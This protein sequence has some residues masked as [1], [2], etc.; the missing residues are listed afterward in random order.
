[1]LAGDD[2]SDFKLTV[3]QDYA[4]K[5]EVR[6]RKEELS[7]LKD[8]YSDVELSDG[9]GNSSS[10]SEDEDAKALTPAVERDFLKTLSLLKANDPKIY[11]KD[12]KFYSSPDE[13]SSNDQDD[14]KKSKPMRLKDYERER[15]LKK[16]AKSAVESDD[17]NSDPKRSSSPTYMEEQE[18]LKRGIKNAITN[19]DDEILTIRKKTSQELKEEENAYVQWLKGHE[20]NKKNRE[21]SE[22]ESLR[23]YWTDPDLDQN[24]KFLRDFILNK[25]YIEKDSGVLP[26]YDE[27]VN[28]SCDEEDEEAIEKQ[29]DFERKYNFRFE[30]PDSELIM[31]YPRTV[32]GSVRRKD[33]SRIEKRKVRLERK[34]EEKDRKIQ[35][36]K[37]LKNLKKQEI[38]D[39]IKKLK[40]ITGNETLGFEEFDLDHE[41]DPSKYDEAMQKVF[42]NYDEADVDE[43][44]PIFSDSDIDQHEWDEYGIYRNGWQLQCMCCVMSLLNAKEDEGPYCEDSEFNMDADFEPK[45]PVSKSSK[46]KGG[47]VSRETK[48]VK[49]DIDEY[50]KLN[51]EDLIGDIPCRFKYRQVPR[52]DFG[53]SAAEILLSEDKELNSWS[54]LKKVVQYGKEEGSK[55][56]KRKLTKSVMLKKARML[57]SMNDEKLIEDIESATLN[58]SQR[59][60]HKKFKQSKKA[61]MKEFMKKGSKGVKDTSKKR[62]NNRKVTA[63]VSTQRLA[64]YGLE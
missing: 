17:E 4:R 43:T 52:E 59:K 5:Y 18:E 10:E 37:R 33:S 64:A 53:L 61:I 6:K 29:E 11:Q 3:N 26:T 25:G 34:A 14:V 12:S 28:S 2:C 38:A 32:A 45:K 47:D 21:M 55:R 56:S 50:Y 42:E 54:S 60:L 63:R 16:G 62:G 35:D 20:M 39:K 24:E 48:A 44:K 8:Q 13:D 15:L 57:T 46:H 30:E 1:M 40:E 31:S 49:Q 36:L 19:A 7:R 9:S 22:M 51:Y 41:F 23:R 27:L 58:K